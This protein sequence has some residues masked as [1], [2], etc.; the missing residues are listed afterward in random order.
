MLRVLKII[1]ELE[2]QW[3]IKWLDIEEDKERI[4]IY[5]WDDFISSSKKWIKN[6]KDKEIK[7]WIES[8]FILYTRDER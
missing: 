3:I 6:M 7:D 2:L 4:Y 1:K 8:E 5:K